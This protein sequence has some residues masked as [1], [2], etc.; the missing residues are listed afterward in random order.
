MCSEFVELDLAKFADVADLL[1]LEGGKV[2]SDAGRC[3]V[4]DTSERFI[5]KRANR[6]NRKAASGGGERMDHRL[7]AEIDLARSDDLSDILGW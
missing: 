4:H 6:L 5:E 1:A 2:G 7:E 3:Q